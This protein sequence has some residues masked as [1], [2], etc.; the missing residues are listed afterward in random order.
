MATDFPFPAPT[1]EVEA[2]A[3][4]KAATIRLLSR[5][6]YP[7]G[8]RFRR[9]PEALYQGQHTDPRSFPLSLRRS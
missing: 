8:P 6:P 5:A 1:P 3:A 2:V 9:S 4:L 7:E